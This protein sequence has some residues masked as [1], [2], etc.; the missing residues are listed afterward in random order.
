MDSVGGGALQCWVSVFKFCRAVL[1]VVMVVWVLDELAA[2][3]TLEGDSGT[4]PS[5]IYFLVYSNCI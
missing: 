4:C 1:R 2:E 5:G 3:D